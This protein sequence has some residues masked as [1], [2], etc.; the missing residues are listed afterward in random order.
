[1]FVVVY[2]WFFRFRKK[3]LIEVIYCLATR[4][5]VST[6]RSV[7]FR[8]FDFQLYFSCNFGSALPNFI[9]NL[10]KLT[11]LEFTTCLFNPL[12]KNILL[13]DGAETG[14]PLLGLWSRQQVVSFSCTLIANKLCETLFHL[15]HFFD[16]TRKPKKYM[17][18]KKSM[19]M[20]ICVL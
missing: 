16:V 10:S 5:I 6:Y 18:I 20:W 8:N 2:S 3:V 15:Q 4:L 1:M 11:V 12:R 7:N 9:Q 14:A 13:F 17:N 19:S